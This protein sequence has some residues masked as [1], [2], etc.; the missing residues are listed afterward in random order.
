[1]FLNKAPLT[2]QGGR[3]K[4]SLLTRS[5]AWPISLVIF[6][7]CK[8]KGTY[9][10][11]FRKRINKN[12]KNLSTAD[13]KEERKQ[14]NKEAAKKARLRKKMYIKIMENFI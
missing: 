3:S 12:R 1:M 6:P 4:I 8:K 11:I 13:L 7:R 5:R 14:R 2:R 9:T 10:L